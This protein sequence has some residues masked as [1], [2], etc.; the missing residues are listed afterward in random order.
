MLID[1][2]S[3]YV[4]NAERMVFSDYFVVGTVGKRLTILLIFTSII[5][6]HDYKGNTRW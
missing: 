4:R 1:L 2:Y 3:L 5:K 6:E